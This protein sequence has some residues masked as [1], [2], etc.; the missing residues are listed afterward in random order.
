MSLQ[1]CA[2]IVAK[3]DP[4]R[5]RAAMAAPVEARRVLFPLYAFNV[6]VSRAPWV[7]KEPMIAEMR[8]QWWRDVLEEIAQGKQVRRHEVVDSLAPVLDAEAAQALDLL[9]QARRWDIYSDPFEDTDHFWQYLDRTS[10]LLM[11]I[12]ARALDATEETLVRQHGTAAGMARL[13]A[14][15]PA[16]IELGKHPLPDCSASSVQ[17]YA[18]QALALLASG[19]EIRTLPKLARSA[20]LSGWQSKPILLKIARNSSDTVKHGVQVAPLADQTRLFISKF[21]QSI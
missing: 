13:L 16:L 7:T 15:T 1:A 5:F 17:G 8:L 4:V 2:D 21:F 6:E 19:K 20:V 11:W 12:S 10:G 14:A 3:G 18:N 9:V